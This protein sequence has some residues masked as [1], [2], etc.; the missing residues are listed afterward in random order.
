[1]D[2]VHRLQAE[3]AGLRRQVEVSLPDGEPSP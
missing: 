1:M 3:L 2:Q